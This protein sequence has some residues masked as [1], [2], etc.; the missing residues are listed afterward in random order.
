MESA[1]QVKFSSTIP[2]AKRQLSRAGVG[3]VH[4]PTE[5]WQDIVVG[6]TGL[7]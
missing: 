3:A 5:L 4:I 1:F 2:Y 7:G 6:V